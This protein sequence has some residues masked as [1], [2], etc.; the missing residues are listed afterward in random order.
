MQR[1]RNLASLRVLV[2]VLSGLVVTCVIGLA[3]FTWTTIGD[4]GRQA[5]AIEDRY[6]RLRRV[7]VP[8]AV[9]GNELQVHVMELQG[10]LVDIGLGYDPTSAAGARRQV[11]ATAA[12]IRALMAE[13]RRMAVQLDSAE[14]VR[15]AVDLEQ[16]FEAYVEQGLDMARIYIESGWESGNE[17]YVPFKS[18]TE[19]FRHELAGFVAKAQD[20]MRASDVLIGERLGG[21]N[22]AIEQGRTVNLLASILT[23]ALV[24]GFVVLLRLRVVR[25]VGRI[26][27][28]MTRMAAGDIAADIPDRNRGDEIGAMAA[29]LGVFRDAMAQGRRLEAERAAGEAAQAAER[30][31]LLAGIAGSLEQSVSGVAAA[32]RDT[33]GRVQANADT[34]NRVAHRTA[35]Q[36]GIADRSSEEAASNTATVSDAAG[37][38]RASVDQILAFTTRSSEMS[39]RAVGEVGHMAA[40]AETLGAAT[41]RI[42]DVV[43]LIRTIAAQTNLLALNATIEAARAGESGRGFAVV[44]NEVKLL[45]GQTAKA[46]EEI[47][48]QIEA[49]QAATLDVVDSIGTVAGSIRDIDEISA[50]ISRATA[51]QQTATTEIVKGIEEAARGAEAITKSIGEVSE[52]SRVTAGEA[53]ALQGAAAELETQSNRL[54]ATIDRFVADIRAA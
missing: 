44:A 53:Q 31:R 14:L 30:R 33:A 24:G 23:V 16:S 47:A 48:G 39:G 2:A 42:S 19:A 10:I 32:L 3:L 50:M 49:V 20:H 36:A 21:I 45:A 9:L 25:P 26:T 12:R 13:S 46:T 28:A 8:L 52:G 35:D 51:A 22:A 37:N 38:M 1:S 43:T 4:L 34:V 11:D 7:E 18:L 40:L 5:G 29:A 41:Q 54:Q 6:G 27:G 15:S 17:A